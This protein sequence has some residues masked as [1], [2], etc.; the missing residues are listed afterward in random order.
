MFRYEQTGKNGI[1]YVYEVESKWIPE[2]KQPRSIK[3]CLGRIN[4][5]TGELEPTG[6]RG[7]RPK[8]ASSG[9]QP[10]SDLEKL[11]DELKISQKNTA[12]LEKRV[13][14][15]QNELAKLQQADEARNVKVAEIIR[16]L[17]EL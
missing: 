13:E 17:K 1:T 7:R 6:P 3:T 11:R 14:Y 15:L 12:A 16:R 8:K 10:V 4:P 9:D 2:L 5:E